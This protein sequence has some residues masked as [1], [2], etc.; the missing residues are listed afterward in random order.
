ML[1]RVSKD[2][3]KQSLIQHSIEVADWAE[4]F[5]AKIGFGC[6]MRLAGLLHDAG[7]A[8]P[9]FQ[10]Y[11]DQLAQAYAGSGSIPKPGSVIHSTQ[12]A[13]L[14]IEE[15]IASSDVLKQMT[16]E[17]LAMIIA[18]HHGYLSD[19]ISVNGATPLRDRLLH[20]N[21]ALFYQQ[22]ITYLKKELISE[23]EY[24]QL[25]SEASQELD[26]FITK[27]KHQNLD[28]YFSLHLLAKYLFSCLI[29]AD[30]YN[31][32]CFEAKISSSPADVD[33]PDWSPCVDKLDAHIDKFTVNNHIDQLRA[34]VSNAC[35]NAARNLPG[36]YQLNIPTGG[37][38]TLAS[39]RFALHHAMK[40][41]M[42]RIVYIIPYL[43]ILEQTAQTVREILGDEGL[44]EHHSNLLPEAKG[45]DYSLL[46]ERWD[47]KL[48]FTTMVQFLESIFSG[49]TR[50]LRKL[51]H[52]AGA[53]LIFDEIQSL[54]LNCVHL[55]NGAINYLSRFCG[56]TVLLCTA[57]QPLLEH[58][59][60]RL[61]L[62]ENAN[63]VPDSNELFQGFQRVRLLPALVPNGYT[64]DELAA[65]ILEKLA[66]LSNG[67]VVLNTRKDV[68]NLYRALQ[69]A[70]TA[71]PENKCYQLYHL[72]T[73][74]CPAHRLAVL[75]KVKGL[76][77]QKRLICVSTQLIEAG[78]DISFDC[79]IRALAGLDSILQAL[80]RCNRNGEDPIRDCYVIKVA[81]EDLS[82]LP[83]I[84]QGAEETRRILS[85]IEANPGTYDGNPLSLSA[86]RR[87]YETYFY[88][89]S[90]KMDFSINKLHTSIYDLL[91]VNRLGRSAY[92]SERYTRPVLWYAFETAGK[93]FRVIENGVG[94]L[95][96][97]GNGKA[98]IAELG[99]KNV[100]IKR[101]R[102]LLLA[103][104][105]YSI[106]LFENQMK[107]LEK[108]KGLIEFADGI[109]AL[110]D[111]YYDPETGFHMDKYLDPEK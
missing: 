2:G 82:K 97:Y 94:V 5:G 46:S 18:N 69:R 102:E 10:Q 93:N 27:V 109:S 91:S 51:H 72:N 77:G 33:S 81:N 57:T 25:F 78:V 41:E 14:F 90:D 67:L 49:S 9:A 4:M 83:D 66:K 70:N 89:S 20:D 40:N 37:G 44:L 76:L 26:A 96:P 61:L 63:I 29:D 45:E 64:P 60:R 101:K 75:N 23:I 22:T 84:Q 80:G 6:F 95:V 106:N 110:R 3:R 98:I 1:A 21:P 62:S 59:Q 28:T 107:Q 36:V 8:S 32:Y 39:L 48:I 103:A 99:N 13:K 79:V 30:R 34:H 86:I 12:A 47:A 74:M 56:A 68:T 7:K 38:K 11:M 17:L 85:A 58:T 19:S 87:Y 73:N 71:L 92:R 55:F 111:E 104:G 16:A 24:Q 54:P 50:G 105:R 53:V 35:M 88:K 65:F 52:L 31:A 43:S 42:S 100:D 15:N 108:E